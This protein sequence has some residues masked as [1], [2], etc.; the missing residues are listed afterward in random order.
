MWQIAHYI[1]QH[2]E[3]I[4]G[5]AT[6][7]TIGFIPFHYLYILTNLFHADKFTE[8]V[9]KVLLALLCGIA[10]AAGTAAFKA[11]VS[12]FKKEREVEK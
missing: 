3:A 8:M 11:I 7:I 4:I 12:I 2:L 5:T 9:Y 1:Y 6:G 10:G